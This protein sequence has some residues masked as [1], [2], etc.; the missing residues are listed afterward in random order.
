[1]AEIEIGG[2]NYRTAKLNARQQIN[3]A[4]R[5]APLLAGA[6]ELMKAFE[7][8][9]PDNASTADPDLDV[10]H[11][12]AP[13]AKALAD[14]TDEDSD[15]IVTTCLR[16]TVRESNNAFVPVMR[17]EMQMFDD[18]DATAVLKIVFAVVQ[19]S[20]GGFL[21]ALPGRRPASA[22]AAA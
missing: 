5:L 12:F 4:R 3:V 11:A 1:M 22:Q 20:L 15:Y 8:Y 19:E 6:G 10:F 9:S 18:L 13:L 7:A 21:A 17:G 16:A 2:I 14:L